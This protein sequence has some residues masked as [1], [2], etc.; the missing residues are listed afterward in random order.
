MKNL[1][2]EAFIAGF[3]TGLYGLIV[4]TIIFILFRPD[5]TFK[6]YFWYEI[7]I[8]SFITGFSS[9]IIFEKTGLIKN[10]CKDRENKKK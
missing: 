9:H 1:F 6:N 5:F 3:I 10:A 2:K 7:L 4:G 8:S